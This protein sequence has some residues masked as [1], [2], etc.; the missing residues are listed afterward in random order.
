MYSDNP[1]VREVA[2]RLAAHGIRRAVV[3]AGSRNAPLAHTMASCP[4]LDCLPAVDERSAAFEALG[5]AEALREP[6]ALCV[7]SGSALLDAAPAVAEAYY[8]E[9]PLVVISAD[10]PSAWIDQRDGQ[11]MRQ[12]GALDNCIRCAVSL[13]ENGD[14]W[15]AGRLL[16]QALLLCRGPVPGPVHI[17]V[18]LSEPLF[19]ATVES[20]PEPRV[21]SEER[22]CGFT[23]SEAAREAL[24]RFSRIL[25]VAGQMPPDAATQAALAALAARG[26]A[27][28][29][30]HLANLP[31]TLSDPESGGGAHSVITLTDLIL[32]TSENDELA[33]LAPDLVITVGGHIVCK[34]LKLFLRGLS[35]I[36]H[37]HVGAEDGSVPDLFQHL[38]RIL[39]AGSA[40]VLAAVAAALPRRSAGD[41]A[42]ARAWLAAQERLGALMAGPL[43][44]K[45]AGYCD[46]SAMGTV[47]AGLPENCCLHLANSSPV[48]NAQYF[49][50]PAGTRVF[51]NRGVNGIDGS[52]S[53]AC[54][55]ARAL[56]DRPVFCLI[57]D[58][59]FFY[60]SNAL[61]R[62]SLPANLR[63]A[64][65]NNGGG[66]IFRTLPGLDSPHRDRFIAG[67]NSFSAEARAREA[68]LD[69]LAVRDGAALEAAVRNL[70]RAERPALL[71]IFT[72]AG[73]SAAAAKALVR[74]LRETLSRDGRP[75]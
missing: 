72:D 62:E 13:P 1:L 6:V 20:L 14:M 21:I 50:L 66:N 73:T 56:P 11:T 74:E 29:A 34:R 2:A 49:P 18:P 59:S 69:Y 71:E 15:H 31:R 58:L 26:C 67:S 55:N 44:A 30:E 48:R 54:G 33:A 53:A 32:A 46:L 51:C 9:V 47:L 61:W 19:S 28:S 37:W 52:L 27:I 8:Q 70:A 12:P 64:V 7:T 45:A 17:N 16:S 5:M 60:D 43:P 36:E 25:V 75:C 22:A 68:G 40:G 65:F 24:G 41:Y 39:R 23:L 3:C 38:T 10:R 42:F 4:D 57:G 63:V 35:G